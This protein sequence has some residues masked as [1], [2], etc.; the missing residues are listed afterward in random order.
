MNMIKSIVFHPPKTGEEVSV[1][2]CHLVA[3]LIV[4]VWFHRREYQ[5]DGLHSI[6][7]GVFKSKELVNKKPAAERPWKLSLHQCEALTKAVV[8]YTTLTQQHVMVCGM[9]ELGSNWE[10]AVLKLL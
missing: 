9:L 10:K 2:V 1:Q 3:T 7:E 8:Q 6:L 4:L 5:V